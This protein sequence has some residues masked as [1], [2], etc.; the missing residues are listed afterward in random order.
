[1]QAWSTEPHFQSRRLSRPLRPTGRASACRWCHRRVLNLNLLI[2][3]ARPRRVC[4]KTVWGASQARGER[5]RRIGY[6]R[7]EL[8]HIT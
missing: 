4:E 2:S 1:M 5:R 6:V 7:R 8:S 3:V